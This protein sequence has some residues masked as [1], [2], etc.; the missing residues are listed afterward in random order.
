LDLHRSVT[1]LPRPGQTRWVKEELPLFEAVRRWSDSE[2]DP[3]AIILDGS[4]LSSDEIHAI[5]HS[6][7]YLDM[8]LG[9]EERR[10]EE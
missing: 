9:F 2:T 7:P 6:G 10:D 1:I 3:F 8:L 5:I 4:A